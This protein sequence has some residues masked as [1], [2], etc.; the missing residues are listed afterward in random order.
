VEVE[1]EVED[2]ISV[3]ESDPKTRVWLGCCCVAVV[4]KTEL[5]TRTKLLIRASSLGPC[6]VPH[7]WLGCE[8]TAAPRMAAAR[9]RITWALSPRR[10]K[11]TLIMK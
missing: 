10:C 4:N 9:M 11:R 7:Y 1:V 2:C 6:A 3:S 8:P 5:I